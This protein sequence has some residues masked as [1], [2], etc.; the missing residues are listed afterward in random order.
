MNWDDLRYFLALSRVRTVS[1][2]GRVLAVKHTTVARRLQSL[3]QGLGTKLFDRSSEGYA[4]T[5]AGE[6]LYQHALI[7]E[8]QAQAVDRQIFGLDSQLQ[9][10]LKLT[11]GH[12][13]FSLLIA[14]Y[15]GLFK[16]AYP[17][18]E[19]QLVSSYDL[20]DLSARQADI[21]LRLSPNP[22]DYLIGK[23][24]LPLRHGVYGSSHYLNNSDKNKQLILWNDEQEYPQW[25]QQHFINSKVAIR[26]NDGASMLACV[27]NH[28]GL[29]RL[30]CYIGDSAPELR[31]LDIE[32]IPSKWGVW[33]LSHVDLRATARVRAGREFLIDI[34]EQQKEL[35]EGLSSQYYTD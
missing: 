3:E 5:Q 35:I 10:S 34:I 20:A 15:L 18:I 14:P 11:A 32:L 29:A 19:L 27:K 6:N 16:R 25:A 8:E 12:D 9:G 23:K 28:M 13:V 22:P 4:M 2:A 17:L 30:P 1:E 33:V 24:V 26:V 31:R 7:M 21:A